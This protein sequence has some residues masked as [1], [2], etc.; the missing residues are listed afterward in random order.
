MLR[1]S[2][3]KQKCEGARVHLDYYQVLRVAPDASTKEIEQAY[4]RLLKEARY[5]TSIDKRLV[6]NAY[7]ILSNTNAKNQYDANQVLR[8]KKRVT[9]V[10]KPPRDSFSLIGWIERRTLPQLLITLVITLA[11]A[12]AF[13]SMRFGYKLKEFHAG[14][15]LY[16][17]SND[18]KF[19]KILR[20][21]QAHPFGSD[22]M[23]AYQVVLEPK[24]K[25]L[26]T[27]ETIVWLPQESVKARCYK[28]ET[29]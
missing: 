3:T 25:R 12:I 4:Q 8:E 22:R 14:D 18:Q 17:V 27:S 23:D 26:G 1:L 29:P 20:V 24:V 13:Y 6:E 2:Y 19:G 16:E 9:R 28:R 15:V 11:I 7:K 10:P 21:E 5:D